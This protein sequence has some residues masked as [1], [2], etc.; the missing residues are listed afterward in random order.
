MESNDERHAVVERVERHHGLEGLPADALCCIVSYSA[1]DMATIDNLAAASHRL[2]KVILQQLQWKC[3]TCTELIFP[4]PEST[5]STTTTTTTTHPGTAKP[6]ICEVCHGT[7]CGSKSADYHKRHCR[8]ELCHGCG[9]QE[10]HVCLESHLGGAD[11]YG[12][13]NYCQ[14]CQAEFEFGMGGC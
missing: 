14:D 2:Q 11:A 10:C 3:K 6:F 12:S 8:P 4:P 9:K 5:I 7:F 13:E 1:A